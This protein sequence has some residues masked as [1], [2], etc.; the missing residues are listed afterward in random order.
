M[1]HLWLRSQAKERVNSQP[2][3]GKRFPKSPRK[4]RCQWKL[5]AKLRASFYAAERVDHNP[6][7]QQES[8]EGNKSD[9]ACTEDFRSY[10]LMVSEQKSFKP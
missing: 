2:P 8:S 3:S 7:W 9:D 5:D 6:P 1:R 4:S 10:R